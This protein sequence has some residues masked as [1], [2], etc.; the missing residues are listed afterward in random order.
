MSVKLYLVIPCYNEEEVL[1]ETVARLQEKMAALTEAGTISPQ[2]RVVFVDDGSKDGTWELIR[3]AHEGNPLFRGIR[4]TRNRGHQN[5]LLAGMMT[6]RGECDA[7]ISLDADLQDDIHAMDDMIR[8]YNEGFD[9]VYGVRSSRKQDS[10]LKRATAQGFY[11]LIRAMGVEI[12]Y[13]HA[14]FRLMSARALAGLAEF[15]EVNLFLRGLVPLVGYRSTTVYYERGRRTAG[16]TKYPFHKMVSFAWE[17]ITSLSVR[18]I[19][20][21]A[22]LGGFIFLGS[23]AV[24]IYSLIRHLGGHTVSG[25]TSLVFSIW[26]LGGIQLL[27]LGI[28]GEY[29]GKIYLEVK[30]RPTYL[31]E[32]YLKDPADT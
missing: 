5:A 17:G 21:I 8:K 32:E 12:V 7:V 15:R 6:V 30:R 1:P 13:N 23:I 11:R 27:A 14:D 26:A 3:G 29:V 16:K 20:M 31:V 19:R 2:S 4:L 10:L 24:L 18:P 22:S 28:I 9:V 25:W